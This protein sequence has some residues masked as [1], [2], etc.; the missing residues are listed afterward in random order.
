MAP[1][2]MSGKK[3]G[4]SSNVLGVDVGA[5]ASADGT[6]VLLV[7]ANTLG[8]P[9]VVTVSLSTTLPLA[10]SARVLF[11]PAYRE[12][13]G[14]VSGGVWAVTDSMDSFSTRVYLIRQ[15]VP[16]EEAMESNAAQHGAQP[17][18]GV[19]AL[20]AVT[21]DPLA[22]NLIFNGDFEFATNVGVPD[23]WCGAMTKERPVGGRRQRNPD[24][25]L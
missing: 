3:P 5:F 8:D 1:W 24:A 2:L 6:S 13:Q 11:G 23:G 15:V 4:A 19:L 22:K 20:P 12:V 25:R 7:V 16:L 9:T 18:E 10:R 17:F 14:S 21:K